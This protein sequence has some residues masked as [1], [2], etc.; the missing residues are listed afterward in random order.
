[1]PMM[2]QLL[3]VADGL[4]KELKTRQKKYRQALETGYA[5]ALDCGSWDCPECY[6]VHRR[7][8]PLHPLPS[9]DNCELLK[10]WACGFAIPYS[11][12]PIMTPDPDTLLD[13]TKCAIIGVWGKVAHK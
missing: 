11:E 10:C 3:D 6:V 13:E 12:E 4:I 5:E 1:M 2:P 7:L 8:L 9:E